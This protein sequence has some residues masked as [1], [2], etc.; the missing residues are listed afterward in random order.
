MSKTGIVWFRQDLRTADNPALTQAAKV[1]DQ[2]VP[3]YIYAPEESGDWPPGAA[4]RWWLHRSL[5]S[6]AASLVRLGSGLILRRGPI[7]GEL[8]TIA[9]QV[10]ATHVFWN[11]LYE[12]AHVGRDKKLKMI[13]QNEGLVVQSFNGSLLF[14][15]W[16]LE[17][18]ERGPYKVFTPFWKAYTRRGLPADPIPPPAHLPPLPA[19]LT[20]EPLSAFELLPSIR[21]DLGLEAV[22]QPG[23]KSAWRRLEQFLHEGL[24]DY[25]ENRDRPD[26]E[27]SSRLSPHLHFGEISPRQIVAA[28]EA[29]LHK[30]NKVTLRSA[31]EAFL[32]QLG[33]REFSY[34]LLYHFPRTPTEPLDVRFA[35]FPWLRGSAAVLE[36]WQ[37]GRTGVP[38]VDAGLRQLWATG[39]IHNRVRMLVASFLTKNLLISWQEG[40]RWFWDTLV[41]A[42]LA[43]NT[44]GWQWVAGCGADAA[45]YFRIFN[46]V[47]QGE[48]FDPLG[49]YVRR[50]VPELGRM[51][52]QWIH[53]PWK[54]P[55]G[56]CHEAGIRLGI[57]YPLPIVDL[58]ISR[59]RAV[60]LFGQMRG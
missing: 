10:R 48:K 30:L 46:P 11:R 37:R 20:S 42:D 58:V 9:R 56:V 28:V 29:H 19:G 49:D 34:H 22:W 4:S 7:A 36:A 39:W 1:C 6:L 24:A 14:E 26:L 13:L 59:E 41:D 32:R 31:G 57:D 27:G 18:Q 35:R 43:N 38:I 17:K 54:A 25:R 3:V 15:P 55:A 40:A 23:E 16:E 50:W 52:P 5:E 47:L 51:P 2:V 8:I 21:W 53:Q 44:Q 33:W 60:T 45:P 12:P